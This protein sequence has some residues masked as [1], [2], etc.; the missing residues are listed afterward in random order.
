MSVDEIR[1]RLPIDHIRRVYNCDETYANFKSLLEVGRNAIRTKVLTRSSQMIAELV[2]QLNGWPLGDI[3][4]D[5]RTA[6]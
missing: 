1:K 5:E 3:S 2:K 6:M 4:D